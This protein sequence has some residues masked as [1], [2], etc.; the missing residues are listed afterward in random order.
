MRRSLLIAIALIAGT[1]IGT[2]AAVVGGHLATPPHEVIESNE[3]LNADAPVGK[4]Y[5]HCTT[6]KH[7]SAL[8]H[9]YHMIETSTENTADG[10]IEH[11]ESLYPAGVE[12]D[13]IDTDGQV[14]YMHMGEH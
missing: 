3:A 1:G 9:K 5:Q 14:C 13:L 10:V 4:Q 7:A 11:W 8:M 12:V 6:P 2:A